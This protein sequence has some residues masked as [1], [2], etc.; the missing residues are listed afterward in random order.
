ME[1]FTQESNDQYA[2]VTIFNNQ[3]GVFYPWKGSLRN[4]MININQSRIMW[5][6]I[7]NQGDQVN[8]D[9]VGYIK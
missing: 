2:L 9:V 8:I 5:D 3:Y 7:L 6:R 1:R 4:L